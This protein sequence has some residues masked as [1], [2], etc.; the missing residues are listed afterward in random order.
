MTTYSYI[1]G[2]LHIMIIQRGIA[3]Y[4]II[5]ISL[6]FAWLFV[7][8]MNG[9]YAPYN[10]IFYFPVILAALFW[11]IKG[12]ISVGVIAGLLVGPFMPDD[13]TNLLSEPLLESS[14]RMF[15]FIICGAIL[16]KLFS[17][18]N[19]QR[20]EIHD[21]QERLAQFS[22]GLVDSLAQA[23]EVRDSYTSG[24]CQRVS[25]MSVRIGER[26][27]LDQQELLRLKWSATLH[28][29]GKIGIPEGVLNKEGKL[30]DDEYRLMKQHPELG[31][32]ILNDIPY[33][34]LILGGVMHHHERMDGKG[35]PYGLSGDNIGLQARIIAVSDVWDALTSKR[36]YRDAMS[37]NEALSIMESGRGSQFDPLILDHFLE[38]ISGYHNKES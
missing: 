17:I 29:I 20:N 38:I 14:V 18:L 26:M 9:T 37:H 16:G 34:D 36:S 1:K 19:N 35:Y 31:R 33:A 22:I 27:G 13:V 23:I 2:V 6:I 28:D 7:Y 10:H 15:F 12:G 8:L 24:H 25:E 32:R 11:G 30:T 5:S 21:H 4:A 3:R